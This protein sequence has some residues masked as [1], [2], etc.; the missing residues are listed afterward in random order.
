MFYVAYL[1]TY[2]LCVEFFICDALR[3]L[4][5][6]VQFKREKYRGGAIIRLQRAILL[7]VSLLHECSPWAFLRLQSFYFF[8]YRMGVSSF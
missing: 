8:G 3:D 6:F 5:T 4:L 7:K 1:S 2:V